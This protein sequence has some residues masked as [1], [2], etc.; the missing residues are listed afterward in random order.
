MTYTPN[1][2][3]PRVQDRCQRALGFLC[4]VMSSTKSQSWSSRYI[5][6]YLGSQR[7]DLSKYLRENLLVVTDE[8]YRYNSSQNKCKEYRLNQRGVDL[9]RDNLKITNIQTYPSVV[10]VAKEDHQT[11]LESG[12]FEYNDKS[13]RYWHPLQRYR[14]QH[15]S[16]ILADYGYQHQYDI[17]TCAPT[18]IHQYSQM[19]PERIDD[20]GKWLQGPMDLYLFALRRYLTDKTQVREEVALA[21]DLPVAAVKEI[22]NALFAGAVISKNKDSDIYHILDGDISRIE[23]LKQDPY[24]QLLVQ[25]IKTCWEY[26]R[27]VMQKR[28]KKTSKGS[29]RLLPINARQKWLLYFELERQV[30]DS[31][32]TY[33]DER[34][35]KYFLIHDGWTCASSID[36]RELSDYVRDKTGFDI[37]F[38]YLKINN[39]ITYPSVVKV[40][41]I[42]K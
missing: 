37:K 28:T 20:K 29:E 17:E 31:V 26:I 27:P 39:I 40:Q 24:I 9:L 30:I 35:I 32:R 8:Y 36:E 25:D 13:N 22:I 38:E 5:D 3:N 10:K 34:S 42:A 2:N 6:K 16:Q 15:R 33:L 7:N 41:E 21:I 18:L 14:K 4:G 23:W 11:E 12:K 1:W 19:I